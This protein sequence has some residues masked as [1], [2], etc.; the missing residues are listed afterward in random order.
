MLKYVFLIVD[1]SKW[2][3]L[4]SVISRPLDKEFSFLTNFKVYIL[5]IQPFQT[6]PANLPAF[7][8]RNLFV[9]MQLWHCQI[10]SPCPTPGREKLSHH[11]LWHVFSSCQ[12][13]IMNTTWVF[14]LFVSLRIRASSSREWTL[15]RASRSAFWRRLDASVWWELYIPHCPGHL[16]R[17]GMRQG[18][19][20]PGSEAPQR[21][22]WPG[23]AWR[24]QV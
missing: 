2:P 13:R 15:F 12:A 11:C 14:C 23:L 21:V 7:L 6:D 4:S 24:V 20:C 16:C 10:L 9:K 3:V 5:G 22:R 19:V 1:H 8:F 18:C 17:A